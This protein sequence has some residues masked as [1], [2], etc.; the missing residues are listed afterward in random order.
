MDSF[1]F[2]SETNQIVE[3]ILYSKANEVALLSDF[4]SGFIQMGLMHYSKLNPNSLSLYVS[5]FYYI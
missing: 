4:N 3:V 2:F 5:N 1:Q